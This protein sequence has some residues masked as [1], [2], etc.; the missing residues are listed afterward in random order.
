MKIESLPIEG[1][2]HVPSVRHGDSRG[3]FF[4]WFKAPAMESSIGHGFSL[5]QANCSVSARGTL[6][7]IHYADVPPG[8]A[9]YVSCLAGRILDVVVDIRVG[10]P[11]FGRWH[12][13]ELSPDVPQAL[14]IAEG[15]GHGFVALEDNS[16]VIYLCSTVYNPSAE[17]EIDP[18][19]V[20]LGIAWGTS[21]ESALLSAKDA[22]A[23]GI[24]RARQE[25][26]LP[27]YE[28]CK[29]HYASLR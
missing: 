4:E 7:G 14:Y 5:A 12:A 13:L 23:P 6:R 19:D 9:K 17:R 28:V 16:T 25:G 3:S 18:F 8:Q 2:P 22:A 10:S 27:D 29:E 1:A 11:T 26:L 21:R 15:L 24:E 20:D